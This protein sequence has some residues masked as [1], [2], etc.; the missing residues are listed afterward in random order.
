MFIGSEQIF[1]GFVV[2]GLQPFCHKSFNKV[3]LQGLDLNLQTNNQ[4]T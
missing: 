1:Y 3:V 4:I 2:N